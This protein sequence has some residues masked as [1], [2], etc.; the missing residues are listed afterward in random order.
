MPSLI[1]AGSH[2]GSAGCVAHDSWVPGMGN[3]SLRGPALLEM[4]D[5]LLQNVAR[6]AGNFRRAHEEEE[7]CRSEKYLCA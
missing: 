6:L 7:A 2:H 3:G 5:L 1:V 4:G